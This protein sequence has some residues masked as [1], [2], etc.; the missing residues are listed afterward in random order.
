[1]ETF[2][3]QEN[4]SIEPCYLNDNIYQFIE[5]KISQK[6]LNVCNKR[7]GYIT[8]VSKVEIIENII[9][10]VSYNI[11]F[12]VKITAEKFSPKEGSIVD[13]TIHM[14]FQHGIICR[15]N[16]MS[17]LISNKSIPD[18]KFEKDLV[19]SGRKSYKKDDIIK[20]CLTKVK[21]ENH[22]YSAVGKLE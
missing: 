14:V 7:W 16:D 12:K 5:E 19:K 15:F 17:V 20:V 3:F 18:F 2:T 6:Y 1:M 10:R 9:D 8:N 11:I 21:Y 4:I 13:A 22:K